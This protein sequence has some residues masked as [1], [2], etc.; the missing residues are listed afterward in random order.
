MPLSNNKTIYYCKPEEA[1][2]RLEQ[3]LQ[4]ANTIK[5]AMAEALHGFHALMGLIKLDGSI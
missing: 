1:G 2:P 4:E 3:A 5:E